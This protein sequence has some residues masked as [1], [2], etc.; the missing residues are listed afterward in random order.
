MQSDHPSN[1]KLGG[2]CL[3]YKSYLSLRIINSNYL[4]ECVRFEVMVDDKVCYFITYGSA[5]KS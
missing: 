5:S 2:A 3:Y 1:E 4:N